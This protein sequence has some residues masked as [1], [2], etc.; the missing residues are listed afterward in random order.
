MNSTRKDRSAT[1][2]SLRVS[3]RCIPTVLG[4]SGKKPQFISWKSS[5]KIRPIVSKGAFILTVIDPSKNRHW[6]VYPLRGQQAGG[7]DF[8]RA[9]L[10]NPSQSATQTSS[11]SGHLPQRGQ[12]KPSTL[13]NTSESKRVSR[14]RLLKTTTAGE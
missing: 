7:R 4:L 5:S 14:Q 10:K 1:P 9:F 3:Q 12:K 6:G 13:G 8:V 2:A 11:P